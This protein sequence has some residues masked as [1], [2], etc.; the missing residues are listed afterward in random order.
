MEKHKKLYHV[1]IFINDEGYAESTDY[2]LKRAEQ[3]ASEKTWAM[4]GN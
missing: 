1:Q 4:L 3:I 2:S